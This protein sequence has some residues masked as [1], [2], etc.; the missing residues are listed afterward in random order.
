MEAHVRVG[1]VD[2]LHFVERADAAV[3]FAVAHE[4]DGRARG[5]LADDGVMRLNAVA[6]GGETTEDGQVFLQAG[7]AGGH[8]F[9]IPGTL[10]DDGAI[11]GE[12]VEAA[13]IAQF[14]H[15]GVI[16]ALHDGLGHAHLGFGHAREFHHHGAGIVHEIVE[17]F[18]AFVAL[19]HR[20]GGEASRN[21]CK[22]KGDSQNNGTGKFH[23]SLRFL[24]LGVL[25]PAGDRQGDRRS[26]L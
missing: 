8:G 20:V 15:G 3:G 9:A 5:H 2:G 12:G 6:H 25:A 10:I 24:G 18:D 13:L 14:R 4:D 22:H 21:P 1:G 23:V 11:G 19:L 16:D 7:D 26:V 17:A